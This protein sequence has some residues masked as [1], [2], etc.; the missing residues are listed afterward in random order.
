[1]GLSLKLK[2]DLKNPWLRGILIIVGTT[3]M[4]N[5]AFIIYAF[6]TPPNLVVDDYYERGKEYFHA[7]KAREQA[8][9]WRLALLTPEVPTVGQ[10]QTYRLYVMDQAGAPIKDGKVT[11]MAYRPSDTRR[12]FTLPL[13]YVDSGTFAGS[14]SFPLPGNWDLIAAVESDGKTFDIAQRIFVHE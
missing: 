13:G 5:T 7:E 4:V 11:L 10:E 14:A 6:K 12:D 3:V 1:M 2:Q 8:E 9:A